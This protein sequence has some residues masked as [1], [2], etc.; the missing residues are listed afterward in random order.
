M[1]QFFWLGLVRST[2][3]FVCYAK[4]SVNRRPLLRLTI[5]FTNQNFLNCQQTSKIPS[6]IRGGLKIFLPGNKI[7]C[8]LTRVSF[9]SDH[10]ILR[11]W[12]FQWLFW[13]FEKFRVSDAA[14]KG[15]KRKIGDYKN[16]VVIRCQTNSLV[17]IDS[18]TAFQFKNFWHS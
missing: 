5:F 6:R 18:S 11:T 14:N 3:N 4:K 16:F 9:F 2:Q 15:E 13:L 12:P 8:S 7:L 10:L 1:L 17:K